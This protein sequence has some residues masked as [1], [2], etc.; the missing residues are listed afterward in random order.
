MARIVIIDDDA[1]LGRALT[2]HLERAGHD[3]WQA[4]DGDAGV[5][6]C[7]RHA[8]DVVIV[9]FGF[10]MLTVLLSQIG[11]GRLAWVRILGGSVIGAVIALLM[12][13]RKHP[14]R[15]ELRKAEQAEND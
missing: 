4:P 10:A 9:E 2:K 6:A 1:A 14:L 15:E 12:L 13:S 5:R 7:E 8:A 11:L 3:V